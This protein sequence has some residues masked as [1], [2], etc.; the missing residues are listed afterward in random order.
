MGLKSF[1]ERILGVHATHEIT[2]IPENA[3]LI[4]YKF[5]RCP[6]CRRTMAA[7]RQLDLELEYRD[8]RQ[9]PQYREEL[10]K[11]GGKSQVPCLLI[12]GQPLYESSDIIRSLKAYAQK[13]K[14]SFS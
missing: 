9:N 7:I 13:Q 5:D 6:Y 3:E 8:T 4:L 11:I 12:N 14:E 2:P 10:I 1:L